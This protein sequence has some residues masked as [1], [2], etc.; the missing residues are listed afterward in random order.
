M[1]IQAVWP[2]VNEMEIL[3][4]TLFSKCSP[5]FI[6][7]IGHTVGQM[8]SWIWHFYPPIIIISLPCMA[9]WKVWNRGG[10][11]H[12]PST[13][14]MDAQSGVLNSYEQEA[15]LME[16]YSEK[17]I[18]KWYTISSLSS[19]TAVVPLFIQ[20]KLNGGKSEWGWCLCV[21]VKQKQNTAW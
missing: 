18:Q 19:C 4:N 16:Q 12:A 21:K 3:S 6:F 14:F 9:F 11:H 7:I 5:K 2:F 10:I 17:F 1:R 15:R 8:F 13:R 20:V